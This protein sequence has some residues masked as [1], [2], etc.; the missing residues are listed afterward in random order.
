MNNNLEEIKKAK[1]ILEK[2]GFKVIKLSES[3]KRDMKQCNEM[4]SIGKDKDCL[5]CHCGICIMQEGY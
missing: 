4:N 2:E 5:G 3:M 1:N